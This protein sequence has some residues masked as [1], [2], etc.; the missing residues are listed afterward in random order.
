MRLSLVGFLVAIFALTACS[1]AHRKLPSLEQ[2]VEQEFQTFVKPASEDFARSVRAAYVEMDTRIN[3]G[4]D[5]IAQYLAERCLDADGYS[6]RFSSSEELNNELKAHLKTQI[7]ELMTQSVLAYKDAHSEAFE[8]L[9]LRLLTDMSPDAKQAKLITEFLTRAK[10]FDPHVNIGDIRSNGFLKTVDDGAGLIPLAGDAWDIFK[11]V[12][13][14]PR[15]SAVKSRAHS[16]VWS[17]LNTW[18]PL[19]EQMKSNLPTAPATEAACRASFDAKA[20]VAK[21]NES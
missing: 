12:I 15:E 9:Q 19:L 21:L 14:D 8:L 17:Q 20:A 11:W 10:R 2:Q 13:H 4:F 5:A 7:S 3:K 1:T 18:R 6:N 16:L